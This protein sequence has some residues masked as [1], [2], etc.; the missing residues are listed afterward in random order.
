MCEA[1]LP[2]TAH[3]FNKVSPLV[4]ELNGISH[5]MRAEKTPP[6]IIIKNQKK[7]SWVSCQSITHNLLKSYKQTNL[8]PHLEEAYLNVGMNQLD[9]FRLAENVAKK[10]PSKIIFVDHK[11]HPYLFIA[12]LKQ[13]LLGQKPEL[14]FH[15]YG[16]FTLHAASWHKLGPLLSDFFVKFYVASHRQKLFIQQFL[17]PPFDHI[18]IAPFPV[19]KKTFYFDPHLRE[20]ERKKHNL[21]DHEKIFLY[22]G[23]ISLQK[24]ILELIRTFTQYS[25]YESAPHKLFIAGNFDDLALPYIGKKSYPGGYFSQVQDLLEKDSYKDIKKNIIFAG[26]LSHDELNSYYNM[27]DYFI[28]L[29][30]HND[31]D[32]GM[33][34]AEAANT[35]LPLI[36]TDWGGYTS[37][38]NYSSDNTFLIPTIFSPQRGHVPCPQKA[39]K[40]LL[41]VTSNKVLSHK[42]REDFSQEVQKFISVEAITAK[43]N[44]ENK[45][46]AIHFSSFNKDLAKISNLFTINEGQPFKGS[47]GGYN[48]LYEKIYTS[49]F[50]L[51][52]N[53]LE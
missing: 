28:S 22:T 17:T 33:S 15:I 45:S 31:E 52:Q 35:G 16:D 14:H 13:V 38:K 25:Q 26:Q 53:S 44:Q 8:S 39:L 46:S 20:E 32:Y 51:Q 2:L 1:L 48:T 50:D 34:P 9:T 29:S 7:S 6:I 36:L 27:A 18:S 41:D 42:N 30:T 24:N 47:H 19:D 5:S 4:Q 23:R 12:A 37:F 40:I 21:K 3:I 49:Y 10:N 11:P 43:L